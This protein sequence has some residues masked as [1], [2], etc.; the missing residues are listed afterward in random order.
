MEMA[1]Y[2]WNFNA[3]FSYR[4]AIVSGA[5]TTLELA[6]IA[7]LLGTVLGLLLCLARA[8]KNKLLSL[9]ARAFIEIFRDLPL[10]VILIWLF[11]ALPSVFDLGLTAFDT[12]AIGLALNLGAFTSDI[13]RAGISA[14]PRGQREA[15]LA[16]GLSEIQTLREIVLPQ[17]LHV[18]LP[19]LTGRYIETIKLTSLASVIAVNELLHAGGNIISLTYR[20]LEV[21]TAVAIV[22]FI[23]IAPLVY[24]LS[25][26]EGKPWLQ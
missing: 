21:Y 1:G 9:A 19:P 12:A 15:S 18:I 8:S 6:I 20:P 3:V 17:A 5:L 2:T 4:E 23:M 13:F 14:V 11:Y 16:L 25:R 26:M 10:L 22:Y 24:L 7:I